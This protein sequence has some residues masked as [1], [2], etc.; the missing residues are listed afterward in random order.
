M[1]PGVPVHAKDGRGSGE[2]KKKRKKKEIEKK[3]GRTIYALFSP[4]QDPPLDRSN[5]VVL[6]NA[7]TADVSV[8]W[9]S[10]GFPDIVA[11]AS[12]AVEGT[13]PFPS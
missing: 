3:E 12:P 6:K 13:P 10:V 5:F 2:T 7:N 9:P 11:E 1:P 8:A 4:L